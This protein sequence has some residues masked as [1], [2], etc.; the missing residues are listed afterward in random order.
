MYEV[1]ATVSLVRREDDRDYHVVLR[2]D[3]GASIVVEFAD[4]SCTG[5]IGS[6]F[7]GTLSRA[8]SEFEALGSVTLTGRRVRV[9]GVGFYDFNHNQTGRSRSCFELHP[10]VSV[11]AG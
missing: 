2:D 7:A 11:A 3:A 8:R 10:V 1:V 9:R 6:P 5:A 4:P